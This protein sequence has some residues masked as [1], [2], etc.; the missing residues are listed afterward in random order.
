MKQP[1]APIPLHEYLFLFSPST[2]YN[3]EHSAY[4]PFPSNS[5]LNN[6]GVLLLHAFS[7][8]VVSFCYMLLVL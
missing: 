6:P 3:L 4:I 2:K 5:T 8:L 1:L 7:S